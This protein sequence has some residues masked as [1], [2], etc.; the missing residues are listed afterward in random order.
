MANHTNSCRRWL[1]ITWAIFGA[2]KSYLWVALLDSVG[3]IFH[4]NG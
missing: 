2:K 1:S 3:V 4:T